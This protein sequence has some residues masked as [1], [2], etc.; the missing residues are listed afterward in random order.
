MSTNIVKFPYASAII[1]TYMAETSVVGI[2]L[3]TWSTAGTRPSHPNMLCMDIK[4]IEWTC[5][6]AV[7]RLELGIPRVEMPVISVRKFQG[8]P[9]ARWEGLV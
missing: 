8:P 1:R 2:N 5:V 7:W 9:S 4:K 3:R 6:E